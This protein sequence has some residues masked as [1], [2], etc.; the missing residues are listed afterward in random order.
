MVRIIYAGV[1]LCPEK[2]RNVY[3]NTI[4]NVRST[5]ACYF[6]SLKQGDAPAGV[7]EHCGTD[8]F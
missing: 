6:A 3:N 4:D 7:A 1:D 5:L 8:V 2:I